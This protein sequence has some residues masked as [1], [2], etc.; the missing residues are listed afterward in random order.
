MEESENEQQIK[1]MRLYFK[2]GGFIKRI[3][4]DTMTQF[5]IFFRDFI[6]LAKKNGFDKG[7]W[8]KDF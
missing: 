2:W 1:N 3:E 6:T 5:S 7:I 4:R 8:S